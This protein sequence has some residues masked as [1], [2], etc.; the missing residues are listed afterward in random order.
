VVGVRLLERV[1]REFP[2]LRIVAIGGIAAGN[3]ADIFAAGADS[4]A[5]I[6]Y[7]LSDAPQITSRF[8]GM[9]SLTDSV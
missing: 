7:L 1:R 2:D 5:V 8:V 6:S 4:A 3:I 9:T